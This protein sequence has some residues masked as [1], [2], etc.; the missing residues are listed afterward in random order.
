MGREGGKGCGR[1]LVDQP[2]RRTSIEVYQKIQAMGL[3]SQ[4]RFEVYEVLVNHGPLTA[5]E[6][7]DRFFKNKRQRSSISARMSEL[8]ER[9]VV[10]QACTRP[11]SYTGNNA[12]AWATTDNLPLDPAKKSKKEKQRTAK[13]EN[14]ACAAIAEAY[15]HHLLASVI[16][17]MFL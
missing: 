5:G 2:M 11:C 9:G 15:G 1:R 12:I 4:L 8:E 3:L 14:D 13:E 16:R 17:K 6:V 7:W 10:Y